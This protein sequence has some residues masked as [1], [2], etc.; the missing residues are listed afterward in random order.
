[1]GG[2]QV[3]YVGTKTSSFYRPRRSTVTPSRALPTIS[4]TVGTKKKGEGPPV[5]GNPCP[6]GAVVLPPGGTGRMLVT[7]KARGSMP[8]TRT[9]SMVTLWPAKAPSS[10]KPLIKL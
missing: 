2:P 1:M 7:L 10:T 4:A 3:V 6:P 5:A 8:G 9:P